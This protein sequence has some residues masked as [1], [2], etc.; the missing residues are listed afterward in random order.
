[1]K[2]IVWEDCHFQVGLAL[3]SRTQT[4]VNGVTKGPQM[5][6]IIKRADKMVEILKIRSS[7]NISSMEKK[8]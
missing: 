3:P 2:E 6:M 7:E 1:M 8:Q 5:P 4:R